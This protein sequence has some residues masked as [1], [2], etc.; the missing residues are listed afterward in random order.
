[1]M[2]SMLDFSGYIKFFIGLFALINPIG[3]LPVFISMT[4]YQGTIGR[5]KTNLTAN[6]SVVGILWG[7]L[8]F[9][10]SILRL[11][12]ISIDSFRIAGGILVVTI[13][14]SMISGKLGEDKQNKQEKTETANRESIGVVP[15]ALPLMAGPGAISSTIVWSSRYHGWLNLF[16]LSLAIAIFAFCCWLLFRVAPILVKVLGQTG[17]NVVTRIMG[18]LLMS[19][20]IEFIV[21]GIKAIFPGLL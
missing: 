15:L 11:F 3:I 7:S 19:L 21:T 1:M 12:G 6:L 18:L 17:I 13:A 16:G 2:Q 10:D 14:M 5:N 4:N 9:G 20:G 8:F